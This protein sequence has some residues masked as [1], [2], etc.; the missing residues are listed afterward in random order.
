MEHFT[1]LE[2]GLNNELVLSQQLYSTVHCITA[3]FYMFNFDIL[4][5]RKIKMIL[6]SSYYCCCQ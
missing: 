5:C 2:L 4:V 3:P 6:Q 1:P